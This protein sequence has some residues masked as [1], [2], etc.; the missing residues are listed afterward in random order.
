MSFGKPPLSQNSQPGEFLKNGK[1]LK[2][3]LLSKLS[4]FFEPFILNLIKLIP[5]KRGMSS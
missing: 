5:K 4:K 1:K 3:L 2:K